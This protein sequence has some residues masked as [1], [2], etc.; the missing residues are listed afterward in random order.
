MQIFRKWFVL[1]MISV[2]LV[3]AV[4]IGE[5]KKET[6]KLKFVC[7]NYNLGYDRGIIEAFMK[8]NPEIQVQVYNIPVNEYENKLAVMMAGGEDIDLFY[9]KNATQFGSIILK[10]QAKELNDLIK[11]DKFNLKPYGDGLN[12]VKVDEHIYGLPYRND[13]V[14]LYY[15]KDIFDKAKMPY[16]NNKWTWDDFRSTAKKLTAGE[17]NKKI[18]GAFFD[19][20]LNTYWTPGIATGKGD[21]ITGPYSMLKDGVELLKNMQLVDKSAIDYATNRSMGT[22]SSAGYF[23]KGDSA[24]T[25]TGTFFMNT[26]LADK[27]DG[28]HN[29]RW[30]IAPL[31]VWKKGDLHGSRSTI[32]PVVINSKTTKIAAAWKLAKF[33]AGR[34]GAKIMAQNLMMPGYQE[35]TVM[36]FFK[37]NPEFPK[38]GKEALK[39]DKLYVDLP[40]NKLA[41]LIGKMV[42]EELELAITGNKT[43]DAAISEMEKRRKEIVEMNK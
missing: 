5:A 16:P 15:N 31:P 37:Q 8:A 21:L 11:R 6:V 1:L 41:G 9:A 14:I 17:G 43:V 18:W 19:S 12:Q 28:K 2:V 35:N 34:E 39:V 4:S 36:S 33:I 38:E 23:E 27:K 30:G 7:W 24:M 3:S 42:Q 40:A 20:K 25:F 32:T 26:L 13:Y 22:G 29:V 10:N